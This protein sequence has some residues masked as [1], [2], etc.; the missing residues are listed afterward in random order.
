[1]ALPI[2]KTIDISLKLTPG[3]LPCAPPAG[4]KE[5]MQL[6]EPTDGRAITLRP[7]VAAPRP[8]EEAPKLLTPRG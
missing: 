1:M 6:A 3:I 4:F 5:D 8:D 2:G 7:P